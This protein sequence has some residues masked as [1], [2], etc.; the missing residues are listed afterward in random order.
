M[1]LDQSFAPVGSS[2]TGDLLTSAA[3]VPI[4]A[5]TI[6]ECAARRCPIAGRH[7][8]RRLAEWGAISAFWVNEPCVA[9]SDPQGYAQIAA[10]M[11]L[12]VNLHRT[13]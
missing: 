6:A 2:V 11:G 9:F 12:A 7:Y 13:Q 10:S 8:P 1:P 5:S 4:L 3:P